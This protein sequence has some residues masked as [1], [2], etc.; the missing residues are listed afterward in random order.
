MP[1]KLFIM[2]GRGLTPSE[3]EK[4]IGSKAP[5]NLILLGEPSRED[6]ID[7]FAACR[8]FV[9]TSANET[10]GI[11]LLEA[12]A[13]CK[14]VVAANHLGPKEII[15]DGETGA[16]FEPDSLESLRD[17]ALFAWSRASSLGKAGRE[18]VERRYDWRQIILKI[19]EVYASLH[20]HI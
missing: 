9:L 4:H 13:S 15:L 6:A 7:A 12:M 8:V 19:E 10:F 5:D 18:L 3:F 2:I 20:W 11:V 17:K 14:P 16:L 1:N